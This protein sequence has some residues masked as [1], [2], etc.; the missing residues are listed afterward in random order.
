[1]KKTIT[2]LA[3][4]M[5]LTSVAS[6]KIIETLNSRT[7][8][9]ITR[10]SILDVPIN[11]GSKANILFSSKNITNS[12]QRVTNYNCSIILQ[13]KDRY[14]A[15]ANITYLP[16]MPFIEYAIPDLFSGP[17][18]GVGDYFISSIPAGSV[19]HSSGLKVTPNGDGS[20]T[21]DKNLGV[22]ENATPAYIAFNYPDNSVYLS[23][24]TNTHPY[25]KNQLTRN[26]V[27]GQDILAAI[28]M[29]YPIT[30]TFAHFDS[31][32]DAVSYTNPKQTSFTIPKEVLQEWKEV[33]VKNGF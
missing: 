9:Q 10:T 17:K 19:Y 27:F 2:I 12:G 24:S 31:E 6:A 15:P 28:E 11:A 29:G 22:L 33:L 20:Y 18:V 3:A 7:T 25:K 32:I 14:I 23:S 26:P 5:L 30:I 21:V 8:G 1:M 4:L 16:A 13:Q